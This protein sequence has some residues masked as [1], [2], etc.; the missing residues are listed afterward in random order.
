M[1]ARRNRN[2]SKPISH[3]GIK[4]L[5]EKKIL[6]KRKIQV[7]VQAQMSSLGDPKY[8][9]EKNNTRVYVNYSREWKTENTSQIIVEASVI[10]VPA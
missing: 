9:R 1:D 4:S 5:T 6:P 10:L 3:K 2:L 7:Q 8:L